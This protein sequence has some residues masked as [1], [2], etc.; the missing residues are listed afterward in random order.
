MSG[1]FGSFSARGMALASAT[2]FSPLDIPNT[3]Y[4][5]DAEHRTTSGSDA[6]AVQDM[7]PEGNDSTSG[8][9]M[10]I[11]S[12]H[13]NGRDALQSTTTKKLQ[14]TSFVSGARAQPWE[15]FIVCETPSSFPSAAQYLIDAGVGTTS[16]CAIFANGSGILAGLTNAT[17]NTSDIT[18]PTST[19]AIVCMKFDGTSSRFEVEWHGGSTRR[20][21]DATTLGTTQV[22]GFT[23]CNRFDATD[24][25]WRGKWFAQHAKRGAY[26]TDERN[27]MFAWARSRFGIAL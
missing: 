12:A 1:G 18:L 16:R 11:V 2:S 22:N 6:T 24:N 14:R 25:P 3:L 27:N 10:A 13:R 15:V 23:I 4:F 9:A 26:T 21:F 19:A 20:T 5:H 7:G 8:T 17:V